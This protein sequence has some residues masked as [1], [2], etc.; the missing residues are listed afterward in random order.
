MRRTLGIGFSDIFHLMA[1]NK[2]FY[3]TREGRQ[4]LSNRIELCAYHMTRTSIDLAKERGPC[5]LVSD[6]KYHDGIMPIDT[7]EKTVDELVGDNEEFAL[8][9]E[10]LRSGLLKYGIRHSTLMAN[11]PFGSSAM[12]SNSTSGIQILKN[13]VNITQLLG[14]MILIILII[15]NLLLLLKNGWIRQYLLMN[16]TIY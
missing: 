11:A 10:L 16:I 3:N 4:F 1:K 9:W 6:T 8:D 5:Q 12:V 13:M 15:L 2:K 14:V 7:Y